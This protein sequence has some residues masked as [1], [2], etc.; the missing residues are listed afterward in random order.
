[1]RRGHRSAHNRMSYAMAAT[2]AVIL[3]L[4]FLFAPSRGDL[5]APERLSPPPSPASTEAPEENR[6]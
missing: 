2:I 4:A 3:G 6:P 5:P 1:M